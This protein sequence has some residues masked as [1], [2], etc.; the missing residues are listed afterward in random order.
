MR[1]GVLFSAG[2]HIAVL[3]FAYLQLWYLLFP[4]PPIEETPIAV[5][6]VNLA[7][8]TRATAVTK[9]PPKP[10]AKPDPQLAQESPPPPKPEPPKPEPPPPAP[11]PPPTPPPPEPP[12]P[13]PPTPDPPPPPPAPTPKPE[14]PPPPPEPPPPPPPKPPTP[15]EVK[16]K[17]DDKSFDTLLKNL[18]KKAEAPKTDEPPRP[19][20]QTQAAAATSQPI[21]PLGSQLSTSELDLVKQQIY[22]CWNIPAGARDAEN[23]TPQFRVFMN[24]DGSVR[25]ADLLNSDRLSD[26]FFQAAADSARRALLNPRC[27]PLKFPAEKYDQWRTFTIT[28]DPKDVT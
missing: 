11:A 7:P 12:K 26:P 28:F 1:R 27:Q 10:N 22:E 19:R 5:E 18:A 4:S 8:Q 3:L 25:S 16:K 24:A 13:Q 17:Q 14:P 6:L 2:L 21:A 20:A 9:T 15:Q 23:L